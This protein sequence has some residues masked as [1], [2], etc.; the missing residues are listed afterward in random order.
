MKAR[1]STSR[2]KQ[3]RGG[4]RPAQTAPLTR[5]IV[6]DALRTWVLPTVAVTIGLVIFVV[7]NVGLVE[8]APAVTT[9]GSLALVVL[10]F[11]GL[12][13]FIEQPIGGAL[14]APLLLAFAAL[15]GTTTFYPFYR[16]LNPGTP[17]FS[18]R[19]NRNGAPVTLP[20]HGKPGHYSLIVAGHFLPAEGR[21]NRT[22]TY[23]ISVGRDSGAT[24]RVLDGAF[25]EEW[26][27]QRIGMGRRA[28]LVPV[29]SQTMQV[30][31]AIDDPDGHDLTLALTEL[32]PVAG[33]SV[34]V[35]VYTET[36][37][38]AVLIALGILTVAAALVVDA[39][40]PKGG[41]D[42]LMG[43]VTVATLAAVAIF[44]ISSAAAPGFPQL[45]VAALVGTLAGA[46]GGSLLWQITRR[47]KRYAP[48]AR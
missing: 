18:A 26:R 45:V 2:V 36:V 34:T 16:A 20:L 24:E 31:T 44:R 8:E 19:L 42:G 47:L 22:A 41:S 32:S 29:K 21:Q 30:L 15:W 3:I 27:T 46:I 10:L 5:L 17:V 48:A 7:Y 33:D 25:S 37:P 39:Y 4:R 38:R 6:F 14:G 28:S 1:A 12:R 11:F 35:D 43:T 13:S 23:R 40:R 9:V